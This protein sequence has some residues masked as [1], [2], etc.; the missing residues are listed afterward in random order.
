[1]RS[2]RRTSCEA[3][4]GFPFTWTAPTSH[5]SLPSLRL[6]TRRRR[7]SAR[8]TRT[9]DA[10]GHERCLTKTVEEP[11]HRLL[12]RELLADLLAELGERR[13]ALRLDARQ[14]KHHEF[15]DLARRILDRERID[16]GVGLLPLDRLL[17]GLRKLCSR[18]RIRNAPLLDGVV[19]LRDQRVEG[20]P[21]SPRSS[22]RVRAQAC[23]SDIRR[24]ERGSDENV[25]GLYL[26]GLHTID[27]RDVEAERRFEHGTYLAR[28]HAENDILELRN[29]TFSS[30]AAAAPAQVAAR[31]S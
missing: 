3:F 19:I 6:F 11:A 10:N 24:I 21:A 31:L 25:P 22:H 7:L 9:L 1:M 18:E 28:S 29:E 30:S 12:L 27:F 5:A 20:R 15:R 13:L 16:D 17:V 8:S 23:G 26:R 4:A 2:P 14:L